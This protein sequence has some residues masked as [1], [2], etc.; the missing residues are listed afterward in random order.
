MGVTRTAAPDAGPEF[1]GRLTPQ[2]G[3]TRAAVL[4][5]ATIDAAYTL[6]QEK[7]IGSLEVGKLADLIVLDRNV[8]AIPEEDIA[9]VRVLQTVVGGVVRYR[10][11]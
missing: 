4:R 9:N 10:G 6:R 8:L 11:E 2:P 3:M 5:A 7:L 1:A